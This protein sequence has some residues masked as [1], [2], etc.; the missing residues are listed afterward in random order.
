MSSVFDQLQQASIFTKLYLRYAYQLVRIRE[1]EEWET[2]FNTSSGHYEY[3]VMPLSHGSC[4]SILVSQCTFSLCDFC[5][6][7]VFIA[8]YSVYY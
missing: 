6:Y 4:G 3:L 8:F 7:C 2:G 5:F 1:R